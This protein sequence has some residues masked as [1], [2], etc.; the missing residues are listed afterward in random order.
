MI[1][2]NL[3]FQK[4]GKIGKKLRSVF[5]NQKKQRQKGRMFFLGFVRL[6]TNA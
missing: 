1:F 6:Q 2:H 5:P 3:C 4:K